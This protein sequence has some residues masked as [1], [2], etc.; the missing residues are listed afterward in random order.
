ML[1]SVKQNAKK[2]EAIDGFDKNSTITSGK[3]GDK[4]WS[5]LTSAVVKG[6]GY[7]AGIAT[8]LILLIVCLEVL[9]R[10][11]GSSLQ[12]ADELSGYLNAAV[13]FLGLGYALRE[14]AFVRVEIVYDK[15]KGPFKQLI[16]ALIVLTSLAFTAILTY[17]IYSHTVYLFQQDTRAVSI[18]N[19]PEWIPMTAVVLGLVVLLIQLLDFVFSRFK[20]IP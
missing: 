8:I 11:F 20:K 4:M 2:L 5:R 1:T 16:N 14:G 9:I 12:V 3:K 10:A 18:M 7:L 17:F 15:L 6:S 19:T 13:I